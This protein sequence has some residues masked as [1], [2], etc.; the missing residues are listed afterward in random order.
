[1]IAALIGV[2]SVAALIQF[3][4]YCRSAL[5]SVQSV[6][7]SDHVLRVA[8]LRNQGLAAGDFQRF[9]ELVQLCPEQR[10]DKAGIRAVAHYYR[11]LRTLDTAFRKLMPAVS[12][13]AKREQQ[14]CSHFAAV[15]LD[16]RISSSRDLFLQHA[17]NRP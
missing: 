6:E 16:R 8:G 13:W 1:M 4:Y 9:F 17:I 11:L 5:A 12:S 15:M 2:A 7:L 3:V 14:N 10:T